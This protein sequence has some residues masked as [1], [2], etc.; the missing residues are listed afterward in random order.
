MNRGI[1]GM[2]GKSG[3]EDE[4]EGRRTKGLTPKGS[5][6]LRFLWLLLFIS[7]L[8]PRISRIPRFFFFMNCPSFR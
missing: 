5:V 2:R 4:N 3:I 8:L 1:N 7:L 6:R